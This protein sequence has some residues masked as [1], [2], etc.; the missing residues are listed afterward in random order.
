MN[1]YVAKDEMSFVMLASL[2]SAGIIAGR[3]TESRRSEPARPGLGER[4]ATAVQWLVEL[5]RR[6]AVI[7]ELGS[8]SDHELTDIGLN[9]ADVRRVFDGRFTAERNAQRS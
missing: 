2:S 7:D 5:P 4:I 6:Q 1:A 8:L 3:T 9:R